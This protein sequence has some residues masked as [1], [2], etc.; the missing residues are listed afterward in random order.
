MVREHRRQVLWV[1]FLN[2]VAVLVG[3]IGLYYALQGVVLLGI[4]AVQ[5]VDAELPEFFDAIYVS[6]VVALFFVWALTK[7]RTGVLLPPK[8][9]TSLREVLVEVLTLMPRLSMAIWGN[10][11]AIRALERENFDLA[12]GVLGV[13]A[14]RRFVPVR[15]LMGH[16]EDRQ[17]L[18]RVLEGLQLMGVVDMRNSVD[19]WAAWPIGE[20]AKQLGRQAFSSAA[21]R[22]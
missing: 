1:V 17:R 16:W 8:D 20:T 11:R 21:T 12:L 9:D 10:I 2:V 19:G 15:E 7:S 22:R 13:L 6:L 4:T 3:W 18:Q 5:G 14:N